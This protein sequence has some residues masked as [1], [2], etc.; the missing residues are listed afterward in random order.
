MSFHNNIF[1]HLREFC[2]E[3]LL[4]PSHVFAPKILWVGIWMIFSIK[5]DLWKFLLQRRI[6]HH[7]LI[8]GKEKNQ[9]LLVSSLFAKIFADNTEH[10][11]KTSVP[12]FRF[13]QWYAWDILF[14][15]FFHIFPVMLW[16]KEIYYITS[17]LI[18][19]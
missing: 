5:S 13:V 15:V 19:Y 10:I 4:F 18:F 8:V 14:C 7:L 9:C 1:I 11:Y 16:N 12:K 17:S 2:C 6:E 3:M